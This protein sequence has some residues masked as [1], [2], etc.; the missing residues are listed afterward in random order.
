MAFSHNYLLF[1]SVLSVLAIVGNGYVW[2]SPVLDRMESIMFQQSGLLREGFVDG[3]S[4]CGFGTN[5][6]GRQNAA[7][8]VRT[9]FHD[10]ATHDA[11]AGTGGLDASIMFET[12][13]PENLGSAFNNTFGFF[14]S[15]HSYRASMADLIALGVYASLRSCNGPRVPI[16][17]GRIDATEAGP[18][19]VPEP[20][21]DLDTIV[22]K[23]A[24][25]GFSKQDMIQMVACGHS[26]GGVHGN[27][28]PQMVGS[29]SVEAFAHF[30]TTFANY[31]SAV[32]TE[33][34]QDTTQNPLVKGPNETNS[35]LRVFSVDGN[36][37]MEAMADNAV[38]QTTCASILERM[39]NTVPSNVALS[40]PL[41]PL[42]VKPITPKT[43][44]NSDGTITFEGFIRVGTTER[45]DTELAVTMQYANADGTT[46]SSNVIEAIPIRAQGGSGSGIA[47]DFN[48]NAYQFSA[49][50]TNGIS[51]FN[52][53]VK[54]SSSGIEHYDNEGHGFPYRDDIIIQEPQSC[55]IS[56]QPDGNGNFNLTVVA[57][58]KEKLISTPTYLQVIE[59]FP[60]QGV[61]I[62]GLVERKVE[63]KAFQDTTFGYKLLSGSYLLPSVSWLTEYKVINGDSQDDF[64]STGSLTDSCGP[65]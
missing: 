34:L 56:T 58:V 13:R 32:V 12:E 31:D 11:Q 27:D 21:H 49:A 64:R 10:M 52:V 30:D 48:Y 2:P 37:T 24:S 41:S 39:I 45:N 40:E 25:M 17:V 23:F 4:P 47:G 59:K 60:R 16:R 42:P 62:P 61:L 9:A 28:F 1:S 54:P 29:D 33:Y 5:I 35:D 18:P 6:E 63:M 14:F 55:L 36:K 7:E 20:T 53:S 43:T 65:F 51:Q 19:G 22:S 15:F 50:L 26:L 57:A 38:F 44:L 3:V 46:S 8:W